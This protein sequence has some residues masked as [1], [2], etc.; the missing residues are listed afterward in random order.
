[1]RKKETKIVA[2]FTIGKYVCQHDGN[3]WTINDG[4]PQQLYYT[5]IGGV[6]VA[7][8][9]RVTVSKGSRS[10]RELLQAIREAKHDIKDAVKFIKFP[11][12]D[13]E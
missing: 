11:Q 6:C 13:G 10:I 1:V 3:C 2:E 7:L 5:D 8:L 12:A 9:E 4:S